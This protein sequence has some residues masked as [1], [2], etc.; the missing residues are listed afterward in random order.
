[1]GPTPS[2]SRAEASVIPAYKAELKQTDLR[3]GPRFVKQVKSTYRLMF[4]KS[5][6]F[7]E[8]TTRLGFDGISDSVRTAYRL[9]AT[10][11]R[12]LNQAAAVSSVEPT[13]LRR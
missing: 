3:S 9:V 12:R 10:H 11:P 2:G 8:T 6:A 5:L 13:E 4:N 1:M 7:G